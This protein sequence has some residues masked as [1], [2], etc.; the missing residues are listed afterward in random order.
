MKSYAKDE[1]Q[2]LNNNHYIKYMYYQTIISIILNIYRHC[3]QENSIICYDIG[4]CNM[5]C[6]RV[7]EVPELNRHSYGLDSR[8]RIQI[9]HWIRLV[10]VISRWVIGVAL[11]YRFVQILCCL[12]E[13]VKFPQYCHLA[14]GFSISRWWKISISY[15][16]RPHAIKA[17]IKVKG[18]R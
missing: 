14:S 10:D 8:Y 12:K 6:P 16:V 18:Q 2:A 1:R 4:K 13:F 11:H 9:I 5:Q 7:V 15:R 17:M 3:Y